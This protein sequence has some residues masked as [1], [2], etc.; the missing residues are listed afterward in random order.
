MTLL[1]W[2][3]IHATVIMDLDNLES[4]LWPAV[5]YLNDMLA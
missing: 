3:K 2:T 5:K 1:L 4:D